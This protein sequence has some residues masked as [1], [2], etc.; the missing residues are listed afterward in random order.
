[1]AHHDLIF[2]CF[3]NLT[4][5]SC[6]YQITLRFSSVQRSFSYYIVRSNFFLFLSLHLHTHTHVSHF[7]NSLASFSLGS[8]SWLMTSSSVNW[9]HALLLS[10]RGAP[11]CAPISAL[12]TL[13]CKVIMQILQP[14]SLL[15][16]LV[17]SKISTLSG[18]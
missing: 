9:I 16:T 8:L 18:T 11:P 5:P 12:Y 10:S 14:S 4:S 3:S 2:A 6:G 7:I 1:M 15:F 13:R 17:P